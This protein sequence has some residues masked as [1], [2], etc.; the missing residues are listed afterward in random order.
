MNVVYIWES[1]FVLKS[2]VKQKFEVLLSYIHQ[3]IECTIRIFI[4]F[5]YLLVYG[6]LYVHSLLKLNDRRQCISDIFFW[7]HHQFPL[8]PRMV[9]E[10]HIY[11]KMNVFSFR[12]PLSLKCILLWHLLHYFFMKIHTLSFLFLFYRTVIRRCI[13]CM[14]SYMGSQAHLL[15]AFCAFHCFSFGTSLSRN[16]ARQQYGFYRYHQIF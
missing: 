9:K 5:G 12:N 8:S 13:C 2:N 15:W 11:H 1:P 6:Q 14:G 16:C 7:K 10:R 4:K 3:D